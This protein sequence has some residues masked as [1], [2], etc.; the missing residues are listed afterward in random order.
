MAI[1]ASAALCEPAG[2]RTIQ[3]GPDRLYTLPSQAAKN[4]RDGDV[5]EIDAGDYPAD[6]AFWRANNLTIRGVGGMAHLKSQGKT[7]K[8]KA[9]W[10]FKGND[11]TVEHIGFHDAKASA[12][13]GAG[14]RLEGA[15]L[16]VRHSL[17]RD[18]QNGILTGKNPESEVL[19]EHTEFDHNGYG[20]GQS[21]N[22]YIGVIRKF[23]LR[24]S[25]SRRAR[26][27]HQVKSRAAENIITDNKL[28]DEVTGNSSYLI[29]LPVGGIAY[30]ARNTLQ[31]G[32]L[33]ENFTMVS[34]GADRKEKLHAQ[35]ALRVENNTFINDRR[36]GCRLLFVRDGIEPAVV[37]HNRFVG[38]K[39]MDGPIKSEDNTYQDRS[40]LPPTSERD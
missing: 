6:V 24:D 21:H 26:V 19:V 12:R 32:A 36:A 39:K 8:G 15:D 4:A 22:I 29:D 11:T 10:V 7:A 9:I 20:N 18:N 1:L 35:N 33:A 34:F 30:I 28:A 23:T 37:S 14:I 31:Q 38:C 27:G 17:F 3:V 5:I 16:T 25:V 2:A 13:N 40:A